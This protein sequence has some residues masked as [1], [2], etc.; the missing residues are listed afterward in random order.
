MIYTDDNL[1]VSSD[2]SS[3]YVIGDNGTYLREI[4]SLDGNIQFLSKHNH[5]EEFSKN[6]L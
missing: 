5:D 4:I 2:N 3:L 1:V 6:K